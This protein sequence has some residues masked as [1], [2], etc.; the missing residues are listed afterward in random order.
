MSRNNLKKRNLI[1]P[2][3]PLIGR[4]QEMQVIYSLLQRPAVRL[5]TLTGVG[6]VGKTRLA[7]AVASELQGMFAEGVV[8]VSLATVSNP[9]AVLPALAQA[10]GVR[11]AEDQSLLTSLVAS[12]Q[13]Q[14]L[15][16][17]LDNV[18]Q[19]VSIAP[20]LV[21]LVSVCHQLK[22][23]VTSR[24]VLRV[25]GEYEFLVTPLP[26]P[27]LSQITDIASLSEYSAIE[28]FIQR[29][30]AFLPT[31]A[32]NE[33]NAQAIAEI[34]VRLD[35]LPLA[36]ELAAA[37]MKLLP[38]QELLTKLLHRLQ[39][40]TGGA[41]DLPIRQQ[42]LRNTL[43]WSYDLL[44]VEE[45]R[46]FRFL[47][48]FVGG[49]TLR[50]LEEINK[51][52]ADL[53]FVFIDV[54]LSLLDKHLVQRE[55]LANGD[56]RIYMLETIREYGLEL[57]GQ[58]GESERMQHAHADYYLVLAKQAEEQLVDVARL[59]WLGRLEQEHDNLQVALQCFVSKGEIEMALR[60]TGALG[61]F[62]IMHGHWSEGY[63]WISQLLSS[64]D[65]VVVPVRAKALLTA[66][67][68]ALYH[69]DYERRVTL[70]EESLQLYRAL[71]DKRGIA[72]ALN[73]LG[74]IARSKGKRVQAQAFFTESLTLYRDMAD[75]QGCAEALIYLAETLS[76]R[77]DSRLALAYAEESLVLFKEVGDFW[78]VAEALDVLS[79]IAF[80]HE[81][82]ARA[83]S[84]AEE[85]LGLS[86]K[87][88][89]TWGII[90]RLQLIAEMLLRQ[91]GEYPLA[92]RYIEESLELSRKMGSRS[93]CARSLYILAH[94]HLRL[95]E[96]ERVPALLEES[97]AL[98]REMG[99]KKGIALLL[100]SFAYMAFR[101]GDFATARALHE[102][103]LE[104]FIERESV[105]AI[106]DGLI[107]LARVVMEQGAYV[108]AA[109]LLGT[110]TVVREE[111]GLSAIPDTYMHAYEVVAAAVCAHI[112]EEKFIQLWEKGRMLTPQE[113]LQEPERFLPT[114]S[115]MPLSTCTSDTKSL[116]PSSEASGLTAREL[117]VLRLMTLGLTNRQI[118]R[119]LTIS[120]VTV[121]AHVR[122]IYG[123]LG[124]TSRSAATRYAFEHHLV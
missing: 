100:S 24:E 53:P 117:E 3:T 42:T 20:L 41:R 120:T 92:R 110:A 108:W 11:D 102:E 44:N 68:L 61:R 90:H 47:A 98:Y 28:L 12:L 1:S 60:L 36:L 22:L 95:G 112:G 40:L 15:L 121:N 7:M 78:G 70:C 66:G 93:N 54:V 118:A 2:L 101:Q 10:L 83:F 62:W 77:F 116:H 39:I 122:S 123:K 75:H 109:K 67:M 43:S 19:V 119:E 73:E 113:V 111:P 94:L 104:L 69:D 48:V 91:R 124:V 32:L 74:R 55:E 76:S 65:Q 71:G 58:S 59:Q 46:L 29:V 103:S 106:A 16:L 38:L 31:F 33:K 6:G 85:S 80:F 87:V 97:L 63:Q 30:Q 49:C 107:A 51:L 13:D 5:L 115:L 81:D 35:G 84:L 114:T 21:E 89:D 17:I 56:V 23:L 86:R 4:E 9:D 45:Q 57:L 8:F 37:R 50:T 99:D 82:S 64:S 27:D 34:C 105:S 26:L 96:P 14:H 25:R 79:N 72:S 88:A 18:E 52:N